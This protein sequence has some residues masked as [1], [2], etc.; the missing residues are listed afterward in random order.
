MKLWRLLA[1]AV[2]EWK[3]EEIKDKDGGGGEEFF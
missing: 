3:T 2:E 1:T